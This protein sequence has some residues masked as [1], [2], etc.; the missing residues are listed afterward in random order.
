MA[1]QLNH[2][3]LSVNGIQMHV[4]EAGEDPLVRVVSP[5]SVLRD[6]LDIT[7]HHQTV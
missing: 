5:L 4:A 6:A 2:R 7:R 3:I 1:T